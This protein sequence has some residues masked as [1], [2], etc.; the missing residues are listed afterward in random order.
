MKYLTSLTFV[1]F[2]FVQQG[3]SQDAIAYNSPINHFTKTSKVETPVTAPDFQHTYNQLSN[4]L[5]TKINYP[6]DMRMYAIE[7]KS[8]VSATINTK[9]IV[10]DVAIIESL[11]FAF[12]KEIKEVLHNAK[13]QGNYSKEETIIFPVLFRL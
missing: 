5:I 6:V 13:V 12:D 11:G 1:L 10:T 4:L 2:F 7:G 8:V 3:S 9:G